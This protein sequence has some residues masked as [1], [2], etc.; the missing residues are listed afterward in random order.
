VIDGATLSN[1]LLGEGCQIEKAEIRN[2]VI[3]IRSQIADDVKITNAIIMGADYY[4]PPDSPLPGNIPIGI[5]KHS[6][7]EGAIIDKNARIGENVII[8]PFPKGTEFENG[9]WVVR[10]GIVV[11]PKSTILYPGTF[12]GPD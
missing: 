2:A 5:G 4:D 3:G 8:K 9:S 11:V 6:Q 7:I 12:I 10:D 1:V